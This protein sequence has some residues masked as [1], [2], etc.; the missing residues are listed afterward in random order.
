MKVAFLNLCHCD[1]KLVA[2]TARKLTADP[3]FYMIIHVDLKADEQA[4]RKEIGDNPQVCYVKNRRSVSWGSFSAV[5]ATLEMMRTAAEMEEKFDYYILLQN[6]DYPIKSNHQIQAYLEKYKGKEFIRGCRIGG[7]KDWHFRW[8]YKLYHDYE[9]KFYRSEKTK[10]RR[11][12][13]GIRKIARSIPCL[14]FNGIIRDDKEYPLYYGAAQWGM[15]DACVR[16]ILDFS[17]QHERF[18]QKMQH[19][20]FP[21]EEYFHTIVHNSPFKKKCIRYDE[22]EQRWLVNWRNLHYFEYP[23]EITVFVEKDFD[24]LMKREELFCRKVRSGVS[25]GLLDRI[26]RV[27]DRE[28]F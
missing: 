13:H 2:R 23:K 1:P 24:K 28:N 14:A 21:D 4:F 8:K 17:K 11:V 6:L 5:D 10:I 20:Q 19:I 7:S 12:M 3:Q 9:D 27:H 15:T 26:D 22:P 16:Y 25:D 18:H